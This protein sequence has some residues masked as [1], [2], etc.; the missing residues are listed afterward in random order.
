LKETILL[1]N[2]YAWIPIPVQAR[3]SP[4]IIH[5]N[6]HFHG[7]LC[8][9]VCLTAAHAVKSPNP[10]ENPAAKDA[11]FASPISLE[12]DIVL[13]GNHSPDGKTP[14]AENEMAGKWQV[15]DG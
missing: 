7:S 13:W 3:S 12:P 11:T 5:T 8:F 2:K 1:S 4:Q 14:D 15:A 10:T 6:T 9:L